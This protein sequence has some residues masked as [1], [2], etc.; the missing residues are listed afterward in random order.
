MTAH[1]SIAQY[2]PDP[3]SGECIN[4]AVV[5]WDEKG[6]FARGLDDWRRA[7]AFAPKGLPT[8]KSIVNRLVELS[9]PQ[10][11]LMLDKDTA[12]V[13]GAALKKI[14][15]TW[16]HA[17]QFTAPRGSLKDAETLIAEMSRIFL[18]EAAVRRR[19]RP[20][21]RAAAARIAADLLFRAVEARL[22]DKVKD[23]IEKNSE[24]TG[25][26]E[27]H[28]FDVVLGNGRPVAA[29][30]ALSFEAGDSPALKRE[31]DATAWLV[32]DVKRKH[33]ALPVGLFLLPPKKSSNLFDRARR[34][35]PE[36]KGEII[37]E[38]KMAQWAKRQ[39]AV[40]AKH[41]EA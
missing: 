35:F 19:R 21:T 10:L 6:T 25:H 27:S 5:T 15:G 1:Y 17:I 38:N 4:V 34:L 40:V 14:I 18:H 33:R 3:L 30:H 31:V 20:R 29:V 22:P 36:L 16:D 41:I 23:L 32:E 28:R 24:L 7:S 2:M 13:D 9:S 12:Q 8:I 11:N 39:A 26:L 37:P